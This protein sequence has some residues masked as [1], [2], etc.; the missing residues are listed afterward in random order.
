MSKFKLREDFDEKENLIVQHTAGKKVIYHTGMADSDVH[1]IVKSSKYARELICTGT[2]PELGEKIF[3]K[4]IS[5]QDS[6]PD[7]KTYGLWPYSINC[8]VVI[9]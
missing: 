6:E 9:V 1:V 5:L 7:S 2:N 4:V 3:K 8:S